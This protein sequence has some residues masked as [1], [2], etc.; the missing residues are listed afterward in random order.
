MDRTVGKDGGEAPTPNEFEIPS[1][2]LGKAVVTESSRDSVQPSPPPANEGSLVPPQ[3][4]HPRSLDFDDAPTFISRGPVG[5]PPLVFEPPS[6]VS[7]PEKTSQ[8]LQSCLLQGSQR[9]TSATK[10]KPVHFKLPDA[11]AS[12]AFGR[13]GSPEPTTELPAHISKGKQRVGGPV[14]LPPNFDEYDDD[15]SD[16]ES[17]VSSTDDENVASA[18]PAADCLY[19]T[20]ETRLGRLKMPWRERLEGHRLTTYGPAPSICSEVPPGMKRTSGVT[21]YLERPQNQFLAERKEFRR[22]NMLVHYQDYISRAGYRSMVDSMRRVR[23]NRL[24]LVTEMIERET[25]MCQNTSEWMSETR[26]DYSKISHHPR[27]RTTSPHRTSDRAT[28]ATLSSRDPSPSHQKSSS[29]PKLA[30]VA[31]DLL[32]KMKPD[33]APIIEHEKSLVLRVPQH[34]TRKAVE[35]CPCSMWLGANDMFACSRCGCDAYCSIAC[36]QEYIGMFCSATCN[37]DSTVVSELHHEE[38]SAILSTRLSKAND[39]LSMQSNNSDRKRSIDSLSDYVPPEYITPIEDLEVSGDFDEVVYRPRRPLRALRPKPPPSG[40]LNTSNS[41]PMYSSLDSSV[42]ESSKQGSKA[43]TAFRQLP[44]QGLLC[45]AAKVENSAIVDSMSAEEL[46]AQID[47]YAEYER[48]RSSS[49]DARDWKIVN[50][51]IRDNGRIVYYQVEN[52]VDGSRRW[53]PAPGMY[54]ASQAWSAKI[55][56]FWREPENRL[57]L[58]YL[59]NPRGF[60]PVEPGPFGKF[61]MNARLDKGNIVFSKR[62]DD[63]KEPSDPTCKEAAAFWVYATTLGPDWDKVIDDYWRYCF[64]CIDAEKRSRA[65]DVRYGPYPEITA[66]TTAA[67]YE[68]KGKQKQNKDCAVKEH[69]VKNSVNDMEEQEDM[70]NTCIASQSYDPSFTPLPASTSHPPSP[71]PPTSVEREKGKGRLRKRSC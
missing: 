4:P 67:W 63:E 45:P 64:V 11:P 70:D 56:A 24:E 50:F 47:A 26:S 60:V 5:L 23:S 65:N 38:D 31:D 30:P 33:V 36:Q 14:G 53:A 46:E 41:N 42:A 51:E 71:P 15:V 55:H 62:H 40:T 37:K 57:Q 48:R 29:S 44:I 34:E 69:E 8:P 25:R 59:E 7:P 58:N 52:L 49:Q 28:H 2:T 20:Q 16:S 22:H 21:R 17:S 6:D 10:P 66:R 68:G 35:C 19:D 9:T 1:C 18:S 61:I 32:T 39:T 13:P 3:T 27:L 54:I 12:A 43:H